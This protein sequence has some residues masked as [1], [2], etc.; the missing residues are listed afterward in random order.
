MLAPVMSRVR[1]LYTS[2][3]AT[4]MFIVRMLI[5]GLMAILQAAVGGAKVDP[6]PPRPRRS[7][8]FATA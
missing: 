4:G 7:G 3:L 2:A 6:P 1:W 8:S 5:L